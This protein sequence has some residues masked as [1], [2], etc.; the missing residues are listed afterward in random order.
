MS[1]VANPRKIS[2]KFVERFI[3][4]RL[5]SCTITCCAE[6]AP[7]FLLLQRRKN[8]PFAHEPFGYCRCKSN[9]LH[10]AV[11]CNNEDRLLLLVSVWHTHPRFYV[12]RWSR[13]TETNRLRF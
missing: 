3:S 2:I 1:A 13:G 8:V 12:H 5:V 7:N 4:F 10:L 6:I 11:R 9:A